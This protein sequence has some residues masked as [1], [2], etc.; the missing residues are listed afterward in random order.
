MTS[1]D[2]GS[3]KKLDI[4]EPTYKKIDPIEEP[5][6]VQPVKKVEEETSKTTEPTK[7]VEE[8]SST[9]SRNASD[10]GGSTSTPVAKPVEPTPKP[11]PKK[12]APPPKPKT[13][14]KPMPKKEKVQPVEKTVQTKEEETQSIGWGDVSTCE[15]MIRSNISSAL[16][17]INGSKRGKVGT[18]IPLD[19][20]NYAIEVRADGYITTKRQVTLVEDATFTMN[21]ER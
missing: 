2:N 20:T 18:K 1:G 8:G 21:L 3:V 4:P 14:P 12:V 13:Y 16:V 15:L 5:P 10:E 9:P 7:E 17:Y 6:T 19:C 11:E